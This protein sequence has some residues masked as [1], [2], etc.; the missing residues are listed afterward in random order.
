MGGSQG[1]CVLIGPYYYDVLVIENLNFPIKLTTVIIQYIIGDKDETSVENST[2][3]I[4]QAY[5]LGFV[6]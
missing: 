2:S 1:L 4:F 6:I 5:E 3:Q